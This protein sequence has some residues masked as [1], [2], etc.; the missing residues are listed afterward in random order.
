MV[1]KWEVFC[2]KLVWNSSKHIKVTTLLGQCPELI[3]W[4]LIL[5]WVKYFN[6]YP[7]LYK[8][9][10]MS[11]EPVHLQ[12]GSQ[13]YDKTLTKWYHKVLKIMSL[14]GRFKT[15]WAH[16][17][18]G[19]WSFNRLKLLCIFGK[20]LMCMSLDW[21]HET[22]WDVKAVRLRFISSCVFSCV[23]HWC[24]DNFSRQCVQII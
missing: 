18:V 12:V 14:L 9:S 13:S 2:S 16:V 4:F 8:I 24:C 3:Y 23:F 6:V 19:F 11:A 1:P 20:S 15:V 21:E 17:R 7:K 5:I 22:D 10:L